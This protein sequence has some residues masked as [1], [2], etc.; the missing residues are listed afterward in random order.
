MNIDI[1][2]IE[3]SDDLK[4]AQEIRFKVFVHEQ[5]VPEELELEHEE[6]SVH[7]LV[8]MD[9]SEIAT[10]RYREID[11]KIKIERFAVLKEKRGF[12]LGK[13]L[14]EYMLSHIPHGK[15][16]YLN[17]QDTAVNFYKSGGFE[18][19]GN[20]FYEAGIKH[21]KMNYKGKNS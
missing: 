13:K 8:K 21:F 9:G 7:Y 14:L 15:K 19:E 2:K 6:D 18:I 10:G 17:A 12:G 5:N 4:K 16:I 3:K 1:F 20:A 11:G